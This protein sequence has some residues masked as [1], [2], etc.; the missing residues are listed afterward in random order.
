[1]AVWP[2]MMSGAAVTIA[3]SV[4]AG[5]SAGLKSSAL[6][7]AGLLGARVIHASPISGE[8]LDVIF[9]AMWVSVASFIPIAG[10]GSIAT[11]ACVKAAVLICALCSLWGR[12]TDYTVQMWSP[13]YMTADL[14]LILAMLCIWWGI[15]NELVDTF[16]SFADR[17]RAL[18]YDTGI[19]GVGPMD[20][21]QSLEANKAQMPEAGLDG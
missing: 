11:A 2:Y 12:L 4:I 6:I 5:N 15:R 3:A 1:M 17:G 16:Y 18:G 10:Y 13:P 21:V 20:S 14:M 9:A 8:Y 7:L 19:N